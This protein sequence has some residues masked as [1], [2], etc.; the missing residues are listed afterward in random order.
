MRTRL[1]WCIGLGAALLG[2]AALPAAA[3]ASLIAAAGDVACAPNSVLRNGGEASPDHC[4]S[5][6]TAS[7]LGQRPYSAILPLGDLING[8]DVTLSAYLSSYEPHWGRFRSISHPAVGNH[9]YDDGLGAQGYWDYWNGPGVIEGQ[10]GTRGMGW[11]AYD[12][13]RWRLIALNSNCGQVSCGALS[14]QVRWLRRELWRNHERCVL[15][16]FH[17]P[18]FSSGFYAEPNRTRGFWKT[19]YRGG[20]DVVL[21]GHDHLYERFA[22][23]RP[24]GLLDRRRGVSQFTVGTGGWALF[25]ILGPALNSR[26]L[27]NSRFGVLQMWLGRKTYAWSF[28]TAPEGNPIDQGRL[29]CHNNIDQSR[30]P[31]RRGSG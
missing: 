13:G 2:F 29:G 5:S 4:R 24:S 10:G 7:L 20:A 21:N 28:L 31:R 22:P 19:L 25:G 9:E 3:Q 16:Y 15:A 26:F 14:R 30:Q 17:H 11:Y 6:D 27:S 23:Q 12:V 1:G 18:R 8:E